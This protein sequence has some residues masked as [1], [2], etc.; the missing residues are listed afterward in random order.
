MPSAASHAKVIDAVLILDWEGGREVGGGGG[1]R[2]ELSQETGD[3][4]TD[5]GRLNRL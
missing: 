2:G 4:Q 1:V 3:R 5:R